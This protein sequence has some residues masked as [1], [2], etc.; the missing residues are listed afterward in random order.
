MK[1]VNLVLM[2]LLIV[3]AAV[4]LP[5]LRTTKQ[6]GLSKPEGLPWQIETLP[7]G[8]S[9]VFGLTLAKSTIRDARE[10]F[11]KG[12]YLAIVASHSELG[13]LE[14]FYDEADAGGITGKLALGAVLDDKT[15]ERLKR[16]AVKTEHLDANAL[17]YLLNADDM[18]V[19]DQ[20]PIGSITFIPSARFDEKT[21]L[22]RFGTPTERIRTSA[23]VEHLL[24]PEKGLDL[25]LDSRGQEILQYVAPREFA[26][27]RD[28]LV[29]A[30]TTD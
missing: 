5:Y 15:V 28:P 20:A 12:M 19:A 6:S 27:L 7:E 24:Y 17:Q 1:N 14:A 29:K 18:P 3:A 11:G 23:H 26:R 21:A 4:A 9:R 25:V 30:A 13:T 8:G 16:N 2:L 10:R 22:E